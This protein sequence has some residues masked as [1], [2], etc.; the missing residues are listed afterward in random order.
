[1]PTDSTD[2]VVEI[3]R[4]GDTTGRYV[5]GVSSPAGEGTLHV[6]LDPHAVGAR[7]E[8]IQSA[9]LASSVAR[10]AAALGLE[11]P[12]REVGVELFGAVFGGHVR[13]LFLSSRQRAEERDEA[14][15]VVLRIRAPEL[16][17]LPWELL[18][19]ADLGGYLC[20]RDP[21]VRHVDVPELV[22]PLRGDPPLRI[23]GMTALPGS[24]APL[25]ADSERTGLTL[26]LRPLVD[27]GLVRLDWVTGQTAED[28]RRRLLDGCHV[29]HFIGHGAYDP[30]RQEGMIAL[31]DEQG[32]EHLLHATALA[33]LVSVAK[34]RP[35]MVVLNS[36]QGGMG[37]SEDLFSSTASV[38]VRTVPAVVAMQFAVTDKAAARFAASFYQAVA[39]NRSVDEAVRIGRV[40]LVVDKDDSLEWATPVLYLRGRNARLFDLGVT[41]DD[42]GPEPEPSPPPV[43]PAARITSR[44]LPAGQWVHAVAFHPDGR[45]LAT[46]SR[47]RIRVWDTETG[48]RVWEQPVGGWLS[49]VFACAFS[50]DG[51]R[52]ATGGADG[53]AR[54][55]AA[56]GDQL[57]TLRHDHVVTAVAFGP[58]GRH[59]ATASADRSARL[60]DTVSGEPLLRVRHD[61]VVSDVAFGPDGQRLATAS[62]DRSARLWTLSGEPLLRLRHDHGVKTVAFSPTGHR[63]AT[64]GD[65]GSVRLWNTHTG[66]QVLLVRHAGAV[67]DLAYSPDGHR[68]ATAGADH[69]A[70]VW[71]TADGNRLLRVQHGHTV[72]A[73]AFSPDGRWLATGSED[74]TVKLTPLPPTAPPRVGDLTAG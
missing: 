33:A 68:L 11:Q 48:N 65:D 44:V 69:S 8:D 21:V 23:L 26:A 46:G 73:V 45:R 18:H 42:G 63:L 59:L 49:S 31:A 62:G 9:V 54:V 57:L 36:C 35:Q 12:V 34:P 27:R 10:R 50:P 70:I 6:C 41:E 30:A 22:L 28:L 29:L 67:K 32:R 56:S 25:D 61:Q 52:L 2:F 40:A 14:L 66:H 64:G 19:D 37:N 60:W 7:L 58:D 15:R 72:F 20:L 47:R 24:R 4:A 55:W 38:L 71:H 3:G 16:A 39:F 13:S 5:V 17:A 43:P 74:K 51:Q 53:T 1:M